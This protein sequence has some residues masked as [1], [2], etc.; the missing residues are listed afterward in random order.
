MPRHALCKVSISRR[1]R[2]LQKSV[3]GE[4]GRGAGHSDKVISGFRYTFQICLPEVA[5][6]QT[7]ITLQP[8]TPALKSTYRTVLQHP[9]PP[10]P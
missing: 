5:L 3:I 1:N 6:R 2:M 7:G 9:P 4:R 10:P 8:R